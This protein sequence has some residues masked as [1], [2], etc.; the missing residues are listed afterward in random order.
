MATNLAIDPELLNKALEV[1]G[2]K[3]KKATVNRALQEFIAR[4]EQERLLDLFGKLY[5]DDSF[6]YKSERSLG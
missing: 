1:G 4:R 5:W 2:E 3:T 6:D